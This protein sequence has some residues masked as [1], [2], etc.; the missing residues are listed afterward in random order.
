MKVGTVAHEGRRPRIFRDDGLSTRLCHTALFD[1][2]VLFSA[3][4][5]AAKCT[6]ETC[7]HSRLHPGSCGGLENA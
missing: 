7:S 4:P 5:G 2:D 6:V 1:I 3:H